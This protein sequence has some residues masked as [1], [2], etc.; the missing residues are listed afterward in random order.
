MRCERW[1]SW[2]RGSDPTLSQLVFVREA[3]RSVILISATESLERLTELA[4]LLAVASPIDL[5]LGLQCRLVATPRLVD[6]HPGLIVSAGGR[7]SS[8]RGR[9][10]RPGPGA[11]SE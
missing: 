11:A 6:D 8:H 3:C 4:H 7:R 5:A 2:S 9:R 1:T 10:L